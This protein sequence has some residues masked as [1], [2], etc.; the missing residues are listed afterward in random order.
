MDSATS[1]PELNHSIKMGSRGE[2]SGMLGQAIDTP[3]ATE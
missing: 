1:T 2:V 3:Q